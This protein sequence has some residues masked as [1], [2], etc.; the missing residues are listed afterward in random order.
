MPDSSSRPSPP[1][2][3]VTEFLRESDE[4]RLRPAAPPD[5]PA[6]SSGSCDNANLTRVTE[7]LEREIV[8]R[9]YAEERLGES[10]RRFS[11]ILSTISLVA[12]CLD[13]QG[14]ITFC[15]DYLLEMT[16][17]SRHEIMGEN[18][19]DLFTPPGIRAPLARHYAA[20]YAQAAI[21]SQ[22]EY[23][24][25]TRE[26]ERRVI[27]WS[28]SLLR[29]PSG[30]LIG[31]ASIG[32]DVSA[33]RQIE[34]ALRS[35]AELIDLTHDCIM[36]YSPDERIIF[37][38][39]GAQQTFGWS[40]HE[41]V[42]K[43]CSELLKTVFP[44]ELPLLNEQLLQT[45]HWEGELIQSSR[46]GRALVVASR[47]AVQR[48][49]TG[50][51]QA[52]LVI[53]NDITKNKIAENSL[54]E[55]EERLKLAMAAGELGAWEW[56]LAT[57]DEIW[58]DLC[59][60][61][62]GL[63]AGTFGNDHRNFEALILPEELPGQR[64]ALARAIAQRTDYTH[65]YRI[66]RP[67]GLVRWVS[68]QGK[69][70]YDDGKRPV[71]MVGVVSDITE[72][73]RLEEELFKAHK[74]E[75]IGVLAG[76]IAH[77]FNNLLTAILGNITL[78]RRSV[79]A[80][81][82]LDGLLSEAEQ[83]CLEATSLTTQLLTVAK[84]GA[85]VRESTAIGLLI[86]E[87]AQFTLRGSPIC[88]ELL[89]PDDLP[90]V[91]VDTGQ[92]SR[93]LQN[94]I[95][96]AVQAMPESGKITISAAPHPS[97]PRRARQ[98]GDREY[99]RISIQDQGTGISQENL[100]RIFDPFFTTKEN[101]TGLG[102]ACSYSIMAHHEGHI[103]VES[104]PG[105]G[106]TFHLFLPLA[107]RPP[108]AP[109]AGPPWW[110]GPAGA[111]RILVMDDDRKIRNVVERFLQSI[112]FETVTACN[113]SEAIERYQAELEAGT[114]FVAVIMDLTVPGGMGGKEAMERLLE[115]DPAV[116]AIVS[117]GYSNDPV[118]ANFR[119]YGFRSVL[120]KPYQ[121]HDLEQVVRRAVAP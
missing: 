58:S 10:N 36:V 8:Q 110:S 54:R 12:V 103:E 88:C 17:W 79:S 7:Q 53:S 93:V 38:N 116:R 28:N 68:S 52:I 112:G 99:V 84:G 94:I 72:R 96:N 11:D 73:R 90:P 42:G 51:P 66:R 14:R 13:P 91:E 118:M 27:N 19:F 64:E 23:E 45:G 9:Q 86:R 61:I 77:D 40:K 67:D 70:Y 119:E 114:P 81:D 6:Y 78:A 107:D 29:A 111:A 105:E 46:D 62:F 55:S 121:L 16:G 85:P 63:T 56:H 4:L 2:V 108:A 35:Q 89:F 18:W 34:D 43:R 25:I 100:S 65:E 1:T 44:L 24:I 97:P 3:S 69:C 101:S 104:R 26:G 37:W 20:G 102:L 71:R 21:S 49:A 98:G 76:G 33:R 57:G 117:S 120:T 75:S 82:E 48:D 50:A 80:G 113:G 83:G 47:W 60:K 92:L 41:V 95:I 30:R 15:S 59:L 32:L 109:E 22:Q 74:L 5:Q 87:A 31:M 115:I 39:R 106:T